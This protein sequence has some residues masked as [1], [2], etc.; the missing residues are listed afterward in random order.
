MPSAKTKRSTAAWLLKASRL[1]KSLAHPVRLSILQTL[2][3][4]GEMNVTQIVVS[5]KGMAS[6]SQVSQF[7]A[8][9]RRE[10]LVQA[11]RDGI[12][13]YYRVRSRDVQKLLE[14]VGGITFH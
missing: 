6:Q 10:D 7:L 11:R 5:Q 8:R 4:D 2:L 13:V 9:M 12:T 3:R 1:L 14:A